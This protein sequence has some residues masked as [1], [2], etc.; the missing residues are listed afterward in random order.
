MG[1]VPPE[2]LVPAPPCHTAHPTCHSRLQPVG[3]EAHTRPILPHVPKRTGTAARR[4]HN[5]RQ[6]ATL[7]PKV[8]PP[9]APATIGS[10]PYS[11]LALSMPLAPEAAAGQAGEAS[12][13]AG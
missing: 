10:S 2:A 4:T 7:Y 11:S 1:S 13:A 3:L 9:S 8:V 6:P 12:G 5:R